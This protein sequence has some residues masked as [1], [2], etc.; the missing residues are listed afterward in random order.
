MKS[1]GENNHFN[2]LLQGSFEGRLSESETTELREWLN[3]HPEEME[4]YLE[5]CQM[6]SWLRDPTL[7]SEPTEDKVIMLAGAAS[8]PVAVVSRRVNK[9]RWALAAAACLAL[10]AMVGWF[11]QLIQQG[12]VTDSIEYGQG[13]NRVPSGTVQGGA[14]A[15]AVARV[16]RVE[17]AGSV[18]TD[19]KLAPGIELLAGDQI[20]MSEGLIEMAFRDTGVHVI[21]TAPLSFTTNSTERLFL[22]DGEVKLVVPPQGVGFVVETL[23]RK[24]TDLGTS[25]VVTSR[26]EGSKVLVLD[27]QITVAN[28]DGSEEQLMNEGD[29]ANFDPSGEMVLRSREHSGMPEL[30]FPSMQ[31]TPRSVPG[32]IFG[33]EPSVDFPRS[34]VI[35]DFIGARI[36]PLVQ[37]GF[38]DRSCLEG[39]RHGTP[40]RFTG[41]AGTYNQFPKST[42]LVPFHHSYGWLAWYQSRVT[43]P[44]PGRYRFWGYADNKLL[45]AVDG[46]PVF[47]GSRYDSAFR[48]ELKVPRHNHPA[49]PCLNAVAGFASGPWIEVEDEPVQLDLLFGEIAG[50]MTSALL[51]V[52]R[53]GATYENTFWGQPKWSLFLTEPP[54]DSE[55]AELEALRIHMEEK[56]MGSFSISNKSI[57]SPQQ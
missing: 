55:V 47:E 32:I 34:A 8:S 25:F 39:M 7:K 52:E 48:S 36:M 20:T 21:A 56:L 14:A 27:G 28:R 46:K 18:N 3:D 24:I 43:A 11:S 41:I 33:F 40:L 42:G 49:F 1:S 44:Q 57:W 12:A 26:Q 31:L 15:N 4:R 2:K 17:G 19:R 54:T 16:I 13:P 50:N 38:Q 22:H 6:E 51:L 29:L 10:F 35:E 9:E 53:E 5:H 37:S 30:S 45:V 23:D